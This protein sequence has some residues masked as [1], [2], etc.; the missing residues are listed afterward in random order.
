MSL[1]VRSNDARVLPLCFQ[2]HACGASVSLRR[3]ARRRLRS[4][5]SARKEKGKVACEG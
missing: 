2:K 3:L 5:R 1:L 4:E